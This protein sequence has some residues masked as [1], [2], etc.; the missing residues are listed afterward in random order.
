MCQI[1]ICASFPVHLEKE[2]HMDLDSKLSAFLLNLCSE[3]SYSRCCCHL[4]EH[5]G[6]MLVSQIWK[7]A[8]AASPQGSTHFCSGSSFKMV[9]VCSSLGCGSRIYN[10]GSYSWPISKL[11]LV[12][13][14]AGRLFI[15]SKD[16][17]NNRYHWGGLWLIFSP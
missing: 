6:I 2:Y 17:R 4:T 16:Y 1:P 7:Y 5:G 8:L 15:Y 14:S 12:P 13:K 9:P 10:V 11:C 3:K